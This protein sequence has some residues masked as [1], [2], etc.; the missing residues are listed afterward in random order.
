MIKTAMTMTTVLIIKLADQQTEV[1]CS[2][3]VCAQGATAQLPSSL[4]L[5]D[6]QTQRSELHMDRDTG[7]IC[8]EQL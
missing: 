3:G 8:M 6:Q 4:E 1:R 5:E 2:E 7:R